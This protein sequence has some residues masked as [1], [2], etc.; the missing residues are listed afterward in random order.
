MSLEDKIRRVYAYYLSKE[1]PRKSVC[2]N[3]E[4]LVSFCE[5]RLPGMQ[6]R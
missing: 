3:E 4:A 5:G 1:E 2:P 6:P